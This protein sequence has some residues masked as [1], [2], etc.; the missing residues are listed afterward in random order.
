MYSRRLKWA[1]SYRGLSTG[2][3]YLPSLCRPDLVRERTERLYQEVRLRSA[4][5]AWGRFRNSLG[6]NSKG[7][8][9]SS[10]DTSRRNEDISLHGRDQ[11]GLPYPNKNGSGLRGIRLTA[12]GNRCL[13]G[14][15]TE[16][17]FNRARGGT[18]GTGRRFDLGL[19]RP[20]KG[21]SH[22]GVKN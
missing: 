10:Q 8:T 6:I 13:V 21:N 16:T 4:S 12:K 1:T 18:E 3:N 20:R 17:W 9:V 11:A 14:S 22:K 15:T 2:Y 5:M 7:A 19:V